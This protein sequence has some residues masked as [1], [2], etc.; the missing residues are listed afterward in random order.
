MIAEAAKTNAPPMSATVTTVTIRVPVVRIAP[1]RTCRGRL[2]SHDR[3]S[4][5]RWRSARTA[6]RIRVSKSGEA[7]GSGKAAQQL[8]QPGGSTQLG[9]ARRAAANMLRKL[10]RANLIELIEKVGVDQ[11]AGGMVGPVGPL[12]ATHTLYKAR[13]ARKV[14]T[15]WSASG[16]V[17]V[18]QGPAGQSRPPTGFSFA[19]RLA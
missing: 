14:A 10:S 19:D 7:V 2:A 17:L 11:P 12:K 1:R 9:R 6:A 8:H 13:R 5:R 18:G 16:A 4:S 3:L 15:H